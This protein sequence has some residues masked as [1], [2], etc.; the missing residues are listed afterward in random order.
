MLPRLALS[1]EQFRLSTN[2]KVFGVADLCLTGMAL[3]LL[4]ESDRLLFPVGMK[5]EGTLNLNRVKY[6]LCAVV[7]NLRGD[8]VGCEFQ[9]I[10]PSFS[11][12]LGQWLDPVKLGDSLRP[13]P[14]GSKSDFVWFNGRSGTEIYVW[15]ESQQSGA[16]AVRRAWVVLWGRE[17]VEWDQLAGVRTGLLKFGPNRDSV[18][19][20]LRWADEQLVADPEPDS[21][22][23]NL[24]KTILLSSKLPENWKLCLNAGLLMPV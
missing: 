9:E 6:A 12:A 10:A 19:G 5:F 13:I 7:R 2:G 14:A 4:D 21:A 20:M 24:A 18:Q 15:P 3:T 11:E 16:P 23:L 17:F 8:H 1:A 22:K